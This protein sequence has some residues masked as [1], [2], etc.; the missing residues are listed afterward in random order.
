MQRTENN[1][2][3]FKNLEKSLQWRDKKFIWV[4]SSLVGI[5]PYEKLIWVTPQSPNYPSFHALIGGIRA[6]AAAG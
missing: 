3:N 1:L 4:S 2:H 6:L 5:S